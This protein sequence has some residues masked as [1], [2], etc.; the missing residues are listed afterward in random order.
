MIGSDAG[1][2]TARLSR[3][4]GTYRVSL[5]LRA[6]SIGVSWARTAPLCRPLVPPLAGRTTVKRGPNPA[7]CRRRP[8][9]RIWPRWVLYQDPPADGPAG[10]PAGN[11]PVSWTA[12]RVG[13][14]HRPDE[15]SIGP[16][17]SRTAS[18]ATRGSRWRSSLRCRLDPAVV[19][20]QRH[21]VSDTGPKGPPRRPWAPTDL[22]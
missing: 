7:R 3:L 1:P 6:A 13:L 17:A 19:R 9:S 20:G 12:S 5:K 10:P 8:S 4:C 15:R 21:R 11:G 22:R 18:E 14:L 2:K 16:S